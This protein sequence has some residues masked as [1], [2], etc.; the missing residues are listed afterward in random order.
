[1]E[2]VDLQVSD[3]L[4]PGTV[5]QLGYPPVRINLLTSASGIE[6]EDCWERRIL[7]SIGEVDAVFISYEDLIANKR[8]SGRPRD[9]VDVNILESGTSSD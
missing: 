5:I 6:F 8:A 2:S 9:E 7:V 4:E 3:L 1:M